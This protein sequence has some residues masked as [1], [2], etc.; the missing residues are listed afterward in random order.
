MDEEE[1]ISLPPIKA[2]GAVFSK[3]YWL[4]EVHLFEEISE[5]HQGSLDPTLNSD[6]KIARTLISSSIRRSHY[7]QY[8]LRCTSVSY[9][10]DVRIRF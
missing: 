10:I 6:G 5:N 9:D 4:T 3:D 2:H 8:L 7:I 1:A